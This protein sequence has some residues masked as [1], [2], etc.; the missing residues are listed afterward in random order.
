MFSSPPS[1]PQ[2]V[3]GGGWR[4]HHR[5]GLTHIIRAWTIGRAQN[6]PMAPSPNSCLLASGIWAHW[7]QL[8]ICSSSPWR[9]WL[10]SHASFARLDS[11]VRAGA[12]K[13]LALPHLSRISRLLFFLAMVL[14]FCLSFFLSFSVS[15]SRPSRHLHPRGVVYAVANCRDV[16]LAPATTATTPDSIALERP[17]WLLE[18]SLAR[19]DLG[20]GTW[21]TAT[22][23][24]G[25]SGGA[26]GPS[27]GWTRCVE[28]E[29]LSSGHGH[30]PSK[31]SRV[32]ML[33]A[34]AARIMRR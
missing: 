12:Q 15:L 24:C 5:L 13:G 22:A 32:E 21:A 16:A 14:S 9:A 25:R 20:K 7:R 30:R 33:P 4:K 3:G 28:R 31:F 18:D 2:P 10:V 1:S 17:F 26:A 34:E 23:L 19:R 29:I 6:A 27:P 11:L 8:T